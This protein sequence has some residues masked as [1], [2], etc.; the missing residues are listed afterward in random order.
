MIAML[1]GN[2]ADTG[3]GRL[4]IDVNGVGYDV[5][6]P[7]RTALTA[8]GELTLWIYT[9][10]REDAIQL[11]GFSSKTEKE[12]FE[13]LISVN[14]VGPRIGLNALDS[15]QPDA[16]VRAI[17][18]GDLRVLSQISG[19][20]K[21]T[22]ERI[23]LELKGKLAAPVGTA[24]VAAPTAKADDA[25]ALAL[26]QLGFKKSEIDAAAAR[27]SEEGLANAPVAER[28]ASALRRMGAS[29]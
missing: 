3:T 11:F 7:G 16:L 8:T 14:Q 24:P 28:I 18:G 22:A 25:F 15:L 13:A 1:R 4:V 26:A 10:V 17:N 2:V 9:S 27:I 5:Q 6:V 21:K 19:V 12:L 29:R 23:V 20:G